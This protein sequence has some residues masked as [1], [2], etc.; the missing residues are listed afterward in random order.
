MTTFPITRHEAYKFCCAHGMILPMETSQSQMDITMS[1][2][3]ATMPGGCKNIK[4]YAGM[5][6]IIDF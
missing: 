4:I 2:A 3:K 6:F 5:M 1:Y